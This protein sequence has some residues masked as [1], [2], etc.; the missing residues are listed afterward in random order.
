VSQ[1]ERYRQAVFYDQQ[2]VPV[3]QE[4]LGVSKLP[5][6]ALPAL[7]QPMSPGRRRYLEA[8]IA[9][10]ADWQQL[11]L[12]SGY[13][14]ENGDEESWVVSAGNDIAW[15]TGINREP[16][17]LPTNEFASAL[18]AA[19]EDLTPE[20]E[21][22]LQA[23]FSYEDDRY[24]LDRL[25]RFADDVIETRA[26]GRDVPLESIEW[27]LLGSES[28]LP[29]ANVPSDW[30]SESGLDASLPRWIETRR[31][32]GVAARVLIDALGE[33]QFGPSDPWRRAPQD[34]LAPVTRVEDEFLGG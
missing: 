8:R 22:F 4:L 17:P 2:V 21:M 13:F 16:A 18:W 34:R 31:K 30:R 6:G 24:V 1:A 28:E 20:R 26:L 14:E 11:G 25:D 10:L 9:E 29:A 12:T 19:E 3:L 23:L 5:T 27:A 32:L 15:L 33:G 7:S